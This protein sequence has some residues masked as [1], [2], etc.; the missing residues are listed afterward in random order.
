MTDH[1]LQHKCVVLLSDGARLRAWALPL[2]SQPTLINW[3]LQV[4][5]FYC[6]SVGVSIHIHGLTWLFYTYLL[7]W[8]CTGEILIKTWLSFHRFQKKII[9]LS[10]ECQTEL[11]MNVTTFLLLCRHGSVEVANLTLKLDKFIYRNWILIISLL[12]WLNNSLFEL[13][14]IVFMC[15]ILQ[16][17]TSTAWRLSF[18]QAT[19]ANVFSLCSARHHI[20]MAMKY[21]S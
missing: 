5:Q 7:H 21:L 15:R 9:P 17:A 6:E 3:L 11:K 16:S 19:F 1:I 13:K 20:L 10:Y 12:V 2:I 18:N 14:S 4:M 8:W